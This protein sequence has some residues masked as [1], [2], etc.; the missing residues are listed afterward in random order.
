MKSEIMSR[1]ETAAGVEDCRAAARSIGD[2]SVADVNTWTDEWL[3]AAARRDPPNMA[4][5]DVL[6]ERYW[7]EVFGR[8]YML[9]LNH[10]KAKDLAQLAWTR[11]L[12]ARRRLLPGGNF[13]GYI[14][15]VATN[16]WRDALRW[17]R[18]AGPLAEQNLVSMDQPVFADDG[19][20]V[21]MTDALPSLN[22]PDTREQA[23][24]KLDID[25]ALQRLST[26]LRDVLIARFI[27]GES[28]AE[29][30]KRY[31]RTE[32]TISGWIREA[33][34]QMRSYLEERIPAPATVE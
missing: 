28:C 11:V 18:R 17:S 32:Q 5:L 34:Q 3:I 2:E 22:S 8:C 1:M 15:M 21:L 7:K 27:T 19:G 20:S 23:M 13:P 26:N 12:R 9:T 25:Q 30:A 4:A 33:I 6:A 31:Q 29:L 16:L 10:E 24:L 14:S